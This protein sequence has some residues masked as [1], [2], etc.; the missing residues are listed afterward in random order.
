MGMPNVA[1]A[2]PDKA[3]QEEVLTEA[4]PE[5]IVME[6]LTEAP[7]EPAETEIVEEE[8][9]LPVQLDNDAEKA[10][11]VV[12]DH[13]DGKIDLSLN[14]YTRGS[15][16]RVLYYAVWTG[17]NGQDDIQW[18]QAAADNTFKMN[19]GTHKDELGNY[20]C[21]V[22]EEMTDG[23]MNFV[24]ATDFN[25]A[26]I[27]RKD[28]AVTAADSVGDSSSFRLTL[29]NYSKPADIRTVTAAVW[30]KENGQDDLVWYDMTQ[31]ADGTFTYD[32]NI[33]KHKSSG[34]YYVHCYTRSNSGS[35]AYLC[36]TEFTVAEASLKGEV[37]A[38]N[39]DSEKGTCKVTIKG[40]SSPLG[41]TKVQVPVW[42]ASDQ[43]DIYWYEAKKQADGS[44]AVTVKTSMHKNNVGLYNIHV[45][46]TTGDGKTSFGGNTKVTFDAPAPVVTA[47]NTMGRVRLKTQ[48]I[49]TE[50]AVKTVSYDVWS[51]QDGKAD[52][53][54]FT[55]SYTENSHS[56]EYLL[57]MKE[58]TNTGL[59]HAECYV[60]LTDGTKT[61]LGAA[62]FQVDEIPSTEMII[63][64][65][66]SKG[67]FTITVK[68][69]SSAYDVKNV[70]I[71]VWSKPDQ[72]D[73]VWHK[74]TKKSNGDYVVSA[75][76]SNHA[77]NT[78]TFTA[79][80]YVTENNDKMSFVIADKFNLSYSG[81][82]VTVT[83]VTDE[84]QYALK[85]INVPS[86]AKS[87]RFAVWSLKNGQD[88]LKWYTASGSAGVYT[89]TADIK[90]HKTVGEYAVHCYFRNSAN[91]D[92]YVGKTSFTVNCTS[93][94]AFA[95]E[96]S[97]T[98]DG[99]KITINI[100]DASS[101]ITSLRVP[102]WCSADQ[103]DIN[104]YTASL[105]SNG[106]GSYTAVVNVN[107]GNHKMHTGSY[108][109]H[110]Y[111]TFKNGVEAFAG[112]SK[113][114][115]SPS[116]LIGVTNTGSGKRL[117]TL[118]N[119]PAGAKKVQFPVWSDDKG[120]DD[121]VWYD[122]AKQSD[123]SWTATVKAANHKSA[124]NYQVHCY[125]DGTL[126]AR[127]T[128]SFASGEM[129]KNGWYYE[130]GYK[131]YYSNGKKVT[132]VSAIIGAQS[133][134]VAK[135]NRVTCT[136]TIYAND[137]DSS[138]GYIVPVIAFTCSVGLPGTP[139]TAGTHYTFAK[140][141]WKELMGP[142]Y[143]QYATKFTSDGIY[144]HSVAGINTTS[145]NLNSIDYNNLG[146][147]ASHG[148]VRL[149]VRDAKWIYDNCPLGMK[150]IVYDSGDPGPFGKPATIKIPAGQTWDPTDPAI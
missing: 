54:T 129:T 35:M 25:V 74:A 148:C 2:D 124:G 147:P 106:G 95:F 89:A 60:T 66:D 22:Y 128:F 100:T 142:S 131:F 62:D 139:T 24:A 87:V 37:T 19:T 4:V 140:Y 125:V 6:D 81:S 137:P 98:N 78:G 138:K 56:A 50:K 69:L 146:I 51:E 77:Y 53:K 97:A 88:D 85:A 76:F 13:G 141:R 59:Y 72:S 133:S 94:G 145:Y 33:A 93:N 10:A 79:H 17:N 112:G 73:L 130:N 43:N 32:V 15:G 91:K 132:N 90:N 107:A 127:T 3:V 149:C 144:F 49:Y 119:A 111:A 27:T 20:I 108:T 116:C 102:V 5:E 86:G 67:A 41:I 114:N 109:A 39:V 82:N 68:G 28:P 30:S 123:G 44:Y 47:E 96:D 136:V 1:Y 115:Y 120:Q 110:A 12:E 61:L 65:D 118:K 45:Y 21:H 9:T 143:G 42:S 101:T 83:K 135:V 99:F 63:T 122:G 121:I 64:T 38:T 113:H 134:Y 84:T 36:K 55:A 29:E 46:V 14:N 18:Y 34:L 150:V 52:L 70:Q 105:S 40:I 92:V 11:V 117:I 104:W 71:P 8:I 26:S 58:Y 80:V 7:A 31:Q 75:D 126:T 57:N 16:V 23:S 103:S 48:N